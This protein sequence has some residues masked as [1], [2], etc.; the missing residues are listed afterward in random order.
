MDVRIIVAGLIASLIVAAGCG[1]SKP[2]P[3]L[4]YVV[5]PEI[6]LP[7]QPPPYT[8]LVGDEITVTFFYYPE[9]TVNLVVRPDGMVTI[10]LMGDVVAEGVKPSQLERV[11]K[12]RYTDIL[13]EP[14]VSVIVTSFSDQRVIVLGEVRTPGIVPLRGTMT[15]VDAIAEVGGIES[16]GRQDNIILMRR[17]ADGTFRGTKVD[18]DAIL[19]SRSG[20]NIYLMPA[21]VIYVP[22]TAIAKVDQFVDQFVNKLTPVWHFYLSG[23]QV[24][25]PREQYILSK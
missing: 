3:D 6:R 22:M 25:S 11:I 5:Q 4:E 23:R 8:M 15:L 18:L 17:E 24:V 21:D 19:R 14:E 13:A 7:E 1:G 2:E 20:E 10:P 12:E 16:T 9:Y